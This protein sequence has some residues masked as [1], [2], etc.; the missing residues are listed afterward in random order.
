MTSSLKLRPL[1]QLWYASLAS[2]IVFPF[3]IIFLLFN[4]SIHG[5]T[6]QSLTALPFYFVGIGLAILLL[7]AKIR[8]MIFRQLVTSSH[9]D[10]TRILQAFST[11]CLISFALCEISALL[12][13]LASFITAEPFFSAFLSLCALFTLWGFRPSAEAAAMNATIEQREQVLSA[14]EAS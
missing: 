1:Q 11:T 6:L 8:Q 14:F 10:T 5:G 12:G 7:A 3:V 13:F 9:G 2:I 4:Q